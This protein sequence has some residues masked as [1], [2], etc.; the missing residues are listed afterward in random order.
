[1]AVMLDLETMG[2]QHNAVVLTLGCVKFDPYTLQDP[3]DPLYLRFNVDEQTGL[4]RVIDD[5]TMEWWAKQP[6][7]AQDEAFGDDG[8]RISMD[9]VTKQLNKYLVGVDKIWAQGPLFD[10]DIMANFYKMIGKPVPWE[11]WQI[12]DSRTISDM[13]NYSAKTG[14]K[15]AH[16]ALADAYSQAVGVQQIYRQCGVKKK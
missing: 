7:S 5:S 11:Y 10:I 15:D 1:M 13:G 3:Y 12:R 2:F 6:Q 4:G 16:N 14:N 9:D 8:D